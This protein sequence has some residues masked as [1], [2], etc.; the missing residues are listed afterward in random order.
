MSAKHLSVRGLIWPL[1]AVLAA[2]LLAACGVGSGTP[3]SST[4]AATSP[5][6]LQ[7]EYVKLVKDVMPSVV[8]VETPTGLG[9][10]IVYDEHRGRH[11]HRQAVPGDSCRH[12]CAR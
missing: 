9:S 10:G 8:M 2:S 5:G 6:V 3:I 7:S 12:V 1:G 11:E 4:A